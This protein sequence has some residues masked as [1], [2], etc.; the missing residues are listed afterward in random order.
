MNNTITATARFA[1]KWDT[2][3]EGIALVFA[4]QTL[5]IMTEQPSLSDV[6]DFLKKMDDEA[7]A[8]NIRKP[9]ATEVRA[10]IDAIPSVDDWLDTIPH[11]L[12]TYGE[13]GVSF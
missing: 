2:D 10:L 11:D 1:L 7:E 13:V 12:A 8:Q 5:E 6:C 3:A 4:S 9:R